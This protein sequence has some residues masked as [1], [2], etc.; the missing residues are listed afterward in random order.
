MLALFIFAS[1]IFLL[2]AFASEENK[3]FLDLFRLTFPD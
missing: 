3:E 1:F 2:S